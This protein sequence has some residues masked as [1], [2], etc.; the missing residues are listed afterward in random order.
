MIYVSHAID[1]IL[2]LTS[3]LM[4]IDQGRLLAN[5][6]FNE[7]IYQPSVLAMASSLGLENVICASVFSHDQEYGYTE[8]KHGE[9]IIVIPLIDIN[10]G[11]NVTIIIAASNIALS[12]SLIENVTI[13]NQLQGFVKEIKQIGY[14]VL[15]T[16]DIGKCLIVAEVTAKALQTLCI[17]I[18][19]R[20]HCL[21]K[22]Q[23]IRA[24]GLIA[25]G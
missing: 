7:I 9:Q 19:G 21:I 18:G 6:K 1:E 23:A 22:A 25:N 13:Q 2:Y 11:E 10:C 17:A 12:L 8:L 20:V 4:I 5:G 15:V 3:Q 16:V 14:R 24:H